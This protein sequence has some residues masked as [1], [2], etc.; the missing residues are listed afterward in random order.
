MERIV[1]LG[2]SITEMGGSK[3]GYVWQI[4]Q[5][6]RT[7][8]PDAR[9][10]IFNAGISG[11][12][13]TQMLGR[14]QKDVLSREPTLIMISAGINDAYK[15]FDPDHPLG[16]GTGGVS[17]EAY[18]NN[19]ETMILAARERGIE[20]VLLTPT[21]FEGEFEE[22]FNARLEKYVTAARE[23]ASR[24]A[25]RLADQYSAFQDYRERHPS[26]RLTTDTVHMNETGNKLM[27]RVVLLALGV[28]E[29]RIDEASRP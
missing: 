11:Q 26:T 23:L 21:P 5:V 29:A 3:G 2:D 28:P 25:V 6:L 9:I 20:V 13:S 12:D 22:R 17:V 10:R 4:E 1:A 16:G 7:H 18:R 27:A 8:Y 19:I 15:G 24:H 14:F